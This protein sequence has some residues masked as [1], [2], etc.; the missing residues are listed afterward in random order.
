MQ[1]LVDL[2]ERGRETRRY[3]RLLYSCQGVVAAL[4]GGVIV[5]S[6]APGAIAVLADAGLVLMAVQNVI[7]R[8]LGRKSVELIRNHDTLVVEAET[9]RY[10]TEEL[11]EMTDI[12]Q[13]AE[14]HDDAGAV[15][16][17]TSLRLLPDY[18]G[19]LYVFNNSRDRLDL[20]VSWSAS[21]LTVGVFR[22]A[23]M[24][25]PGNC[26]SL[27][28]GKPHVNDPASATLCCMHHSSEMATLE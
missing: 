24:L 14:D 21:N 28:R 3:R 27:K 22:P 4:L 5:L 16:R 2:A 1:H 7:S 13:S 6:P 20:A 17:A 25:V 9:S 12:L 18:A 11:F 15:L 10:R 19:A 26:W 8:T 23:E